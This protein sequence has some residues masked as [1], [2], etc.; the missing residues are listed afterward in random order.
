VEEEL[1]LR[2]LELQ[3]EAEL[4]VLEH[5]FLAELQL[6]LLIIQAQVFQ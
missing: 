3:V 5:L 1:L 4:V 2:H 6:Q